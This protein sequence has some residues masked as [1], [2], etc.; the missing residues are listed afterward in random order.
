[1]TFYF[2]R[3]RLRNQVSKG[4]EFTSAKTKPAR[5]TNLEE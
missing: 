5:R 4:L 2:T 1:M 3:V